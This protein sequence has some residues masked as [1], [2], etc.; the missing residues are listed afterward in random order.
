MPNRKHTLTKIQ[1]AEM[2]KTFGSPKIL[3]NLNELKTH[4]KTYEALS[5]LCNKIQVA[6]HDSNMELANKLIEE[7]FVK[8]KK[9]KIKRAISLNELKGY[10]NDKRKILNFTKKVNSMAGK[11]AEIMKYEGL[12][13]KTFTLV[14]DLNDLYKAKKGKFFIKKGSVLKQDREKFKDA[15][16]KMKAIMSCADIIGEFAPAGISDYIEFNVTFFKNAEQVVNLVDKRAEIIIKKADQSCKSAREKCYGKGSFFTSG[17]EISKKNDLQDA[18]D[19]RFKNK[20]YR[21]W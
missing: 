13:T 11:M 12:I 7:T 21:N 20:R 15:Y 3:R 14:K 9:M 1:L 8:L 6:V 5:V 16:K 4:H 10:L 2:K 18:L 19:R 17:E